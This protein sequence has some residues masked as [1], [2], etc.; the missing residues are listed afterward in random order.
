VKDNSEDT[1]SDFGD[2]HYGDL[3]PDSLLEY[4][5]NRVNADWQ[6]NDKAGRSTDWVG[7]TASV[8]YVYPQGSSGHTFYSVAV[9]HMCGPN[10][11][12]GDECATTP[13]L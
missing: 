9:L 5:I 10:P 11:F 7:N 12:L 13:A 8:I 6:A 3:F 1:G 4:D 2:G